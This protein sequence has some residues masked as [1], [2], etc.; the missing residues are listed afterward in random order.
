MDF[1]L[2]VNYMKKKH[3]LFIPKNIISTIFALSNNAYIIC[4]IFNITYTTNR[5]IIFEHFYKINNNHH[6]IGY[7]E[8]YVKKYDRQI[9]YIESWNIKKIDFNYDKAFD[10][11]LRECIIRD[12][13][14]IFNILLKKFNEKDKESKHNILISIFRDTNFYFEGRVN[15][16]K[17]LNMGDET[18]CYFKINKNCKDLNIIKYLYNE[19]DISDNLKKEI[20]DFYNNWRH[21][22]VH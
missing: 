12:D 14:N 15:Y 4:K 5:K 13:K 1:L 6:M 9:L 22:L 17:L 7:F 19:I 8:K 11:L 20:L 18:K 16:F 21:V 2:C 10:V 3:K